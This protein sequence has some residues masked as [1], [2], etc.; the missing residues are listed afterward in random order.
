MVAESL[1]RQPAAATGVRSTAP[2]ANLAPL[3]MTVS[4]VLLKYQEFAR[5]YYSHDGEPTKEFVEMG[6]ALKPV[7]VLYSDLLPRSS[8][9]LKPQAVVRQ[10]MID[11]GLS[12]GWSIMHQSREAI[13]S[14][15]LSV[16]ELTSAIYE[17]LRTVGEG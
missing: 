3:G 9:L 8:A 15:G 5:E 6:L 10:Q 12:R 13:F 7:R 1:A 2:P 14:N 4:Q 11:Q 16:V 17:G